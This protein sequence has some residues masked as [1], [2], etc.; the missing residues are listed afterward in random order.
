MRNSLD[1]LKSTLEKIRKEQHPEIPAEVIEKIII[2]QAEN[3]DNAFK[4]QSETERIIDDF[5]RSIN[6]EEGSL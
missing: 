1:D 3:Q 6:R 2:A 4:R 5:V